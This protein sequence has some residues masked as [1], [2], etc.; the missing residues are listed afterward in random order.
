VVVGSE[1]GAVHLEETPVETRVA[2]VEYWA[3]HLVVVRGVAVV[4]VGSEVGL[5]GV[6]L[7]VVVVAVDAMDLA[8]AKLVENEGS[9]NREVGALDEVRVGAA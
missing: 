5:S 4:E 8:G 2:E 1:E 6:A 9:A 7:G 3:A